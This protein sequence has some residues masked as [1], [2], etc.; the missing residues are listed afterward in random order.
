MDV[1]S[2]KSE[3]QTPSGNMTLH[4]ARPKGASGA[5]PAVIVIME[6]FGL[7]DHIKRVADRVAGE[8]YHA[9]AP[10]LY[11]RE[12]G[13]VARY[14]QLPEA[15]AMMQRLT[16]GQIVE[17]LGELLRELAKDPAVDG[18]RIGITGFCMGGRISY[19]AACEFPE[20]RASVPFY[21]GGIAGQQFNPDLRPPVEKTA[22]MKA[23]IQLHFGEKDAY[24]PLEVVEEIRRTLEREQKV[25]EVHVYP[26]AA[27]GFFCDE[28]GDYDE[29]AAKLAWSRMTD[30]LARHL[31][32]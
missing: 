7:N 30:F 24:I 28:R 5:L 27:H 9:V 16:D 14:D 32:S 12:G 21:G 11:Y 3:L 10:D 26:G 19:L 31:K 4:V 18:Q 15:I 6:A 25:F 17:D 1:Q 22:K 23:A 20:I 13:K 2:V 29:Q 8:G